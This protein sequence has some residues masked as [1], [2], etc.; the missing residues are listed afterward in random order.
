MTPVCQNQTRLAPSTYLLT[1][2]DLNQY[3]YMSKQLSNKKAATLRLGEHVYL[4]VNSLRVSQC[5][6]QRKKAQDYA[7][8][9][10]TL[11]TGLNQ[12]QV[13]DAYKAFLAS[14][15]MPSFYTRL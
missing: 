15:K 2:V 4:L 14:R 10:I 3:L 5:F 11:E 1:R 7:F 12:A 9:R 6:K 13:V 8:A